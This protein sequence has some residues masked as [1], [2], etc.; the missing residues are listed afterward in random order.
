M[1]LIYSIF[2][3]AI[4]SNIFA[5][6]MHSFIIESNEKN[7]FKSSSF[8]VHKIEQSNDMWNLDLKFHKKS[9]KKISSILKNNPMEKL[10]FK[11]DKKVVSLKNQNTSELVSLS[12][13]L[14]EEE[15]KSLKQDCQ[16]KLDHH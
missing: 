4:T 7:L 13:S 14:S 16:S 8:H 12:L 11:F 3:I 6:S 9:Q 1:R 2:F 10:S 15:V 5:C